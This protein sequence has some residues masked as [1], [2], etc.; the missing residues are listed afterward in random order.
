M[1]L[2]LES[3]W[4]S[5]PPTP[6]LFSLPSSLPAQHCYLIEDGDGVVCCLGMMGMAGRVLEISS[7]VRMLM[8]CSWHT[9]PG[10]S[11]HHLPSLQQ[12]N[13]C[14]HLPVFYDLVCSSYQT[15]MYRK[16]VH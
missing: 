7:A 5:L 13:Y 1:K 9:V 3:R 12:N 6:L 10:V 16:K 15:L 11:K 4:Y 2:P 14:S 8:I